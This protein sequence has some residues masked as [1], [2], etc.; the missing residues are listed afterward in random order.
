MYPF[1]FQIDNCCRPVTSMWNTLLFPGKMQLAPMA[2][3]ACEISD[4]PSPC[5][6]VM[7]L[8]QFFLFAMVRRWHLG[9][10]TNGNGR[11]NPSTISVSAFYTGKWERERNSRV[12]ER[13]RDI[14]DTETGGNRKIYRN[15][16]LPPSSFI[17][18]GGTWHDL[19]NDSLTI[20]LSYIILFMII[21]L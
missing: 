2:Y 13:K 17:R 15:A 5:T 16:L 4:L 19:P 18:H 9:M 3:L 12:R 7:V 1:I 21:N 6:L 20:Y 14:T 10:K 11:E 8:V